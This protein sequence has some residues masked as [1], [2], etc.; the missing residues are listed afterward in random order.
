M[1]FSIQ[2]SNRA[3][4]DIAEAVEF[5]CRDS[6]EAAHRLID[7]VEGLAAALRENPHI[8]EAYRHLRF[9]GLLLA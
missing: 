9:A 2:E 3:R 4:L 7:A 1:A 6:P 5:L 8:V